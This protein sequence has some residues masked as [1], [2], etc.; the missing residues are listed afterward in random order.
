MEH[1]M[2]DFNIPTDRAHIIYFYPGTEI[3]EVDR[4]NIGNIAALGPCFITTR[5]SAQAAKGEVCDGVAGAVPDSYKEQPTAAEAI[6]AFKQ[7]VVETPAPTP[8]EPI[9]KTA[10]AFKAPEVEVT[11]K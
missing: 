7:P 5:N 6:A 2:S 11:E 1:E 10:K 3:T 4:K 8:A 9:T